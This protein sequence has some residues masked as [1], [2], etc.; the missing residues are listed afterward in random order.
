MK[1]LISLFL[2]TAL[3]FTFVAAFSSCD[4]PEEPPAGVKMLVG[5]ELLGTNPSY[6]KWEG[7]YDFTDAEGSSPAKLNLY[8]TASGFTVTFVGTALWV[9]FDATVAG[10]S[11]NHYPYYNVAV[12][13]EVLPT[14]LPERTFYLTGGQQRVAVVEGLPYGEHTV[15]CLKMSEPYDAVTSVLLIETDGNLVE[16]DTAYDAGNFKF[17]VIC[18]SGGSGH[19]ALGYSDDGKGAMG[20][21]TANSSSLH[22]FNYLTARMFGADVQ[23]VANSGWGVSFGQNQSIYDVLDYSGITTS[24]N[25]AGAKQT[26]PWNHQSWVPDVILFNIGGNDT[27]SGGFDQATYQKEVVEMVE[28]LHA[29]YPNAYMIWT[30]TNSNAG[31]YA[32]SAMND[33]G[34][35][36]QD[37]MKVAIIPKV[38]ADGTVGANGHNS[39]ATHIATAEI[40]AETLE[41]TWGFTRVRQNVTL[42][43]YASV[44]KRF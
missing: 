11:E 27:T 31:K 23:F 39:I 28:K 32:V 16:R 19:G 6:V 20:R 22:A 37:Y 29:L 21:N 40:L 9:E 7:R 42:E 13:N 44:L 8:H 24:N 18:A 33:K 34:I 5:A 15:T 1:K 2:V 30:H 35:L 26:A 3:L 41:S 25:V 43:E 36:K 14:T 4:T 38:G 12:D 17:M 10:G